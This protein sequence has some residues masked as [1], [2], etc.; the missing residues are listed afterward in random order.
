[1]AFLFGSTAA[2]SDRRDS[3][4]DI[5]I[6]FGTPDGVVE[7][8]SEYRFPEEDRIWCDLERL[9]GKEVDLVVLN[10]APASL[11]DTVLRKG[12]P[13]VI[14]D[15]RLHL[16]LLI[17]VSREAEDYREFIEDFWNLKRGRRTKRKAH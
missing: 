11:L 8:E 14:R 6:Y 7:W 15:S 4:L 16:D 10:R 17:R 5:G 3:D 9:A 2:S 13:L 12:V 1:M